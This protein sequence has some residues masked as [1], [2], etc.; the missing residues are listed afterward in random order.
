MSCYAPLFGRTGHQQWQP[1][2][3]WFDNHSAYG[4]P[5]Y[6]V[7]KLFANHVGDVLVETRISEDGET[8]SGLAKIAENLCRSLPPCPKTASG[9]M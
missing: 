6:Y 1:D 5:S 3:I 4:T 2:L 8:L 9:S 7:Q